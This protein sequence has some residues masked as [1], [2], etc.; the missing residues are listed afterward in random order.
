MKQFTT[1]C[2]YFQIQFAT[3]KNDMYQLIYNDLLKIWLVFLPNQNSNSQIIGARKQRITNQR[4]RITFITVLQPI[5]SYY[6][7]TLDLIL[8]ILRSN[9]YQQKQNNFFNFYQIFST[10]TFQMLSGKSLTPPPPA[11][12]PYSPTPTSWPWSSPVL[13]HTK[14]AR[15]RGLSSQ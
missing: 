8:M 9:H 14:F 2:F 6:F 10:F 12:L 13:G 3:R 7:Q 4:Y 5:L 11:L 15:P 1:V